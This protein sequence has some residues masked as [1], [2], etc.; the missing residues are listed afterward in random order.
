M[1]KRVE[2]LEFELELRGEMPV[3][4]EVMIEE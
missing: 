3:R 4:S 1:R 2:H